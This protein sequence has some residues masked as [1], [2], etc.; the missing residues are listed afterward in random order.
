MKILLATEVI[1]PGGAETFV[2]R[3]S[4]A[5]KD[6][7]HDV[8]IFV[9]YK[10]NFNKGIYQSLADGVTVR[11]A[12]I[13][14][15]W[16]FRKIDGLFFRLG[17]DVS[18]RNYYIQKSLKAYLDK[19][20]PEIIHSHLLKA[21]SICLSAGKAYNVP[22][23][24]TIHGDYLQ[25]Y[26]KTKEGKSIPLLNYF[27]KA[28]KNITYLQK[29]VCISDKQIDFFQKV[30]AD[31]IP[32]KLSKIY[33]GYNV[34]AAPQTKG[35]RA[36]LN[37]DEDDFVFSMVSRGIAEKGWEVAIQAFLLLDNSNC[38]LLFV[39]ESSYLSELAKKYSAHKNIHF[40]GHKDEPLAWISISD[41]GL[42]P[43]TYAS[44]S[45]PTVVI[46]Y[47]CCGK[48][49]I[50]SDAGEISNMVSNKG[51]KAGIVVPIEQRK[52]PVD[53]YSGAMQRYIEDKVLYEE[54]KENASVCFSQFD[55]DKCVKEYVQVYQEAGKN[56]NY[57]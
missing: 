43:S 30:F 24:T 9:F 11:T 55:M 19:N 14:F 41:A 4:K 52:V 33:N 40:L 51:Q 13:P 21:D 23:A 7:G 18:I 20:K 16:M 42:L 36:S 44:E 2:L 3:L 35:L 56:L 37:I 29:I 10:E 5:L 22:V 49:V 8:A 47:L 54:H 45:L 32:G 38:H 46:E 28:S 50:A 27:K 48:P 12:D 53:K 15:G 31:K 57:N 39:G 34:P 25:F 26:N 6:S 1:H 17:I